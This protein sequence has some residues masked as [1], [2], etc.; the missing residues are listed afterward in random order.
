MLPVVVSVSGVLDELPV[1]PDGDGVV[2]DSGADPVTAA[3]AEDTVAEGTGFFGQEA[4]SSI[5]DLA[6][7][8]LSGMTTL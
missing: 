3:E 7:Q 6:L 8:N 2:G 5:V 4:P 1:V